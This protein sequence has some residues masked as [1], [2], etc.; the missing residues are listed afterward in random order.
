MTSPHMT[1]G[2]QQLNRESD[3]GT[4]PGHQTYS[5]S[6]EQ[7]K[8]IHALA[9]DKYY[10]RSRRSI[11]DVTGLEPAAL[12]HSLAQLIHHH[13]VRPAFGKRSIIFGLRE[14]VDKK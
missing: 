4:G 12:D 6:Q 8:I 5:L 14:R 11:L 13:I 2:G 10:W 7:Q 3:A 9:D 1:D